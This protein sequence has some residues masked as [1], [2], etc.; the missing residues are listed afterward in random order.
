MSKSDFDALEARI[1]VA[2]GTLA[3]TGKNSICVVGSIQTTSARSAVPATTS[4]NPALASGA[5]N[6]EIEE[7]RR[8]Q[9]TKM[10]R[11]PLCAISVAIA[12]ATVDLPSLGWHDV[13][14]IIFVFA[15]LFRSIVNFI[16]R[17]ASTYGH[18]GASMT[19]CM[20]LGMEQISLVAIGRARLD[21]SVRAF[22]LERILFR[23]L[24]ASN[25]T[26]ARHTV[27]RTDR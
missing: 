15:W 8:S 16:A 5:S 2:F 17:M 10:T 7:W 6:R 14:P 23:L 18:D 27:A 19:V 20:I 11:A 24:S 25:G 1:S 26:S 9:S 22:R 13:K 3:P 21:C 4:R 12:T